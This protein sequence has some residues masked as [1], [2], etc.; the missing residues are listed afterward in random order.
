MVADAGLHA[1]VAIID[2]YVQADCRRQSAFSYRQSVAEHIDCLPV[3]DDQQLTVTQ[4][5]LI[6]DC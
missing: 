6:A 1:G 3:T 5:F 4:H 2:L